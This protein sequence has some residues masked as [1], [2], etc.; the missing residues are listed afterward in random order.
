MKNGNNSHGSRQKKFGPECS[1]GKNTP[2]KMKKENPLLNTTWEDIDDGT[3]LIGHAK[4][5]DANRRYI[6]DME[7]V[8]G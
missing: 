7:E 5:G 4:Y 2:N 1:A 3:S 8:E 6:P